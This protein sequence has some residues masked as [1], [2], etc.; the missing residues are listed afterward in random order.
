MP[1]RQPLRHCPALA[2]KIDPPAPLHP[3]QIIPRHP[4]NRG[5][6]R[7]RRHA[8]F[9]SQPRADRSLILL[10]HLPNRLEVIFLRNASLFPPQFRPLAANPSSPTVGA[11]YIV[12]FSPP[13]P[14][15][16]PSPEQ[17]HQKCSGRS[18]L[19]TADSP[20]C[21]RLYVALFAF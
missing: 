18:F 11:R 20:L 5:S 19:G 7:R 6:N 10:E 3:H 16:L 13:Q 17:R 2:S 15:A 1:H 9:L 12:P 21:G 8:Q 4:L 14:T